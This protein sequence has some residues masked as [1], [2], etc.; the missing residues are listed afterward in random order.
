MLFCMEI[1]K[2]FAINTSPKVNSI[3]VLELLTNDMLDVFVMVWMH[4]EGSK[5]LL[6]FKYSMI[7]KFRHILTFECK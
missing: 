1:T 5:A 6:A 2:N 4:S 7:V 3:T